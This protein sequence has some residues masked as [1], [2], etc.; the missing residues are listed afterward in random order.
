MNRIGELLAKRHQGVEIGRPQGSAIARLSRQRIEVSWQIFCMTTSEDC[1][2]A[3]AYCVGLV[4]RDKEGLRDT[5]EA[6]ESVRLLRV[7]SQARRIIY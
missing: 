1:T 6:I 2:S 4:V 7:G 5:S 3:Q